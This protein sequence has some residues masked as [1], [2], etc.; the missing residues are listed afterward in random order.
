MA[1]VR[2]SLTL[3]E[4]ERKLGYRVDSLTYPN[5]NSDCFYLD[6]RPIPERTYWK[7]R[8]EFEEYER[9]THRK[10]KRIIPEGA[11]PELDLVQVSTSL[12]LLLQADSL[13]QLHTTAIQSA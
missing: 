13:R 2:P 10:D 8:Q 9:K 1:K 4:M 5:K 11:L 12:S 3:L 7:T 6:L